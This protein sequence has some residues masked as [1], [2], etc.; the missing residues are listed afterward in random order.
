MPINTK[1]SYIEIGT[2]VS[3]N[4]E[5][6][7]K[8]QLPAPISIPGTDE[9]MADA[10]R[11]SATG[12]MIINKIGRTQYKSTITWGSLPNTTWW[13]IN[14]WF[15]K[16]GYVFYL[17]YFSHTDGRVK[18]HRFYRG[19][20]TEPITVGNVVISGINVPEYYKGCGFSVI[21]MGENNVKVIK[22]LPV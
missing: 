19:N 7:N 2:S 17:K 16:Y 6:V 15:Q 21:D 4:N 10:T 12:A 22:E 3:S 14:R 1:D 18:I 20:V 5:L 8:L 11:S 9:F 13:K